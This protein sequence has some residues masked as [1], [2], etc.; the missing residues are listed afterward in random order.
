M[1]SSSYNGLLRRRLL[2]ILLLSVFFIQSYSSLKSKSASF[3]EV[4]YFGIGKYL[5][6]NQKWDIMGS[7]VH[8]PLTY[9][10]NSLPFLFVDEDKSL[11]QYENVERDLI[12]LGASDI[13]RGQRFLASPENH[14]DRLLIQSRMMT[15][16]VALLLGWYVYR[17]GRDLYGEWAGLLALLLF[18][19][20]P[21]T[22]AL[23][24][25][26]VPDIPLTA[27]SFIFIYYL[28][29]CLRDRGT[30]NILLAGFF[31]GLALLCKFTALIL[32]PIAGMLCLMVACF[33]Q[34]RVVTPALIIGG[35]SIFLLLAGYGFQ[36]TPF[37]QG[38]IYRINQV[39]GGHLSF[40]MGEYS[41][42]GWWYYY[43]VAFLLKTPLAF[44][45]MLSV[46]L[47]FLAK[48]RGAA[49]RDALFLFI[50]AAVIFLLFCSSSYSVALRY[51]LPMYPFLFVL[52]GSL[53]TEET[54]FKP[55]IVVGVL[56]YIGASLYIAPHYLAYFNELA[57]GPDNGYRYL[58]DGNLDWGQDLKGLKKFMDNNGVQR[59]TFSYFGADSPRRYGIDY[60]W[61]PSYHLENLHPDRPIPAPEEQ[62]VAVSATN[63][64]GTYLEP[65]D[66]YA[67]LRNKKPVA[68]IGYSIFVYD[69][70]GKSR[71]Y[72]TNTKF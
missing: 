39:E 71:T 12:F 55:L 17:F 19:F 33:E 57:G 26:A 6:L 22:L 68:K 2:V 65:H 11:W 29:K 9:Y 58:V 54:R 43:P 32:L 34:K 3:D 30:L 69:F 53:A 44:I 45:M 8:P 50:P 62:L 1:A 48:A 28:W 41:H 38:M 47:V 27:F 21:N 25:I 10:L 59:I 4:I 46:A 35:V 70:S 51:I 7:I 60:D 56:W 40:L 13:Y 64:M 37:L 14:N 20:C 16:L 52:A 61:L 15:L 66:Q 42:K 67:L 31:L 24:G 49:L 36:L 18:T 23:S 72:K 5:L 63:L